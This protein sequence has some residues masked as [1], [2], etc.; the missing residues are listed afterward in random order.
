VRGYLE[1]LEEAGVKPRKIGLVST[2]IADYVSFCRGGDAGP[3]GLVI[4]SGDA[5]ELALFTGGRLVAT[6]LLPATRL[7]EP[8][9]LERSLTRQVADELFDPEKTPLYRWSLAPGGRPLPEVGEGNLP[10]LAQGKLAAPETFFASPTPTAVPAVGAALAAVREDAVR[11]NLLP[12]ENREAFDEGPSIT[13]WVLLAT[14]LVLLLVWA[15]SGI[16]KDILLRGEVQA[17]LAE[18]APAVREVKGIQSDIDDLQ[19]QVEILGSGQDGRVTSLLKDLAELIPPDAYLTTLN[20]R[21]TSDAS[22]AGS[23]RA[24]RLTLDGQAKSA[25]DLITALEKSK[26][27]KNVTFSSPTTRQGEKERFSI[28]AEV[29]R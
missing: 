22:Q 25:S 8:G 9:A 19:R 12:E 13:T 6:Q 29:T 20:L 16:A 23:S 21:G 4:G 24:A 5:T 2:A 28:S 26:R 17:R 15:A 14:S 18:V 11:L 3:I 1:A 7:A 27:F 10:G